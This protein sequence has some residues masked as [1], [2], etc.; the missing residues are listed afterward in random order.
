MTIPDHL[1]LFLL[2]RRAKRSGASNRT[3]DWYEQQLQSW[4]AWLNDNQADPMS[5]DDLDAFLVEEA[6]SGLSEST[7][8]A[9]YRAI[10][11]YLRWCVKRK[12]IAVRLDE[13]PTAIIDSPEISE[14]KPRVAD[15]VDVQKVLDS[16]TPAIT[17]LDYR[18]R[19]YLELLRS[20][21]LRSQE[22]C[23]LRIDHVSMTEQY[24]FVLAGKGA[25]DRVV[26]FG[27]RF[28]L[29]FT[30]YRFNRPTVESDRLFIA[31]NTHAK[32]TADFGTDAARQMMERRCE[33]A[34]VKRINLHSIRHMFAIESLNRG[35]QLSAVSACLGHSSVSFTAKVYA[36]WVLSGLRREYD[37]FVERV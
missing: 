4:F 8:H 33:A 3:R 21:G 22:A 30:A 7:V 1:E 14:R 35:M 32:P 24:I 27:Q 31:A 20:T 25:K 34:Q 2:S 23:N 6:D 13:L 11:A 36:K 17:W 15:P 9:R 26:P 5:A 37:E 10:R 28:S 29:A 12:K 19:A 16:M 18:D